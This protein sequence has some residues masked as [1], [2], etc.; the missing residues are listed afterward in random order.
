MLSPKAAL[1]IAV[2]G[3]LLDQRFGPERALN[4]LWQ[5][6]SSRPPSWPH[7]HY[8]RIHTDAGVELLTL[9]FADALEEVAAAHGF[10][11]HRSWWVAADALED[12]RWRRGGGKGTARGWRPR[13]GQSHLYAGAQGGRLIPSGA[14]FTRRRC[15]KNATG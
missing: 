7:D 2:M 9:R 10:R 8:L 1:V 3:F 4:L 15:V 5:C 11:T 6:E 14:S 12:V 13:S